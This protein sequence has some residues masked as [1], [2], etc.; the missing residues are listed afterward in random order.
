M[1][2]IYFIIHSKF[3]SSKVA[4]ILFFWHYYVI[5]IYVIHFYVIYIYVIL[6]VLCV[7]IYMFFPLLVLFQSTWFRYTAVFYILWFIIHTYICNNTRC[8]LYMIMKINI[9][10]SLN[11]FHNCPSKTIFRA[12][13]VEK[14]R[15]PIFPP[16]HLLN[17]QP[18][19]HIH[20]AT[21]AFLSPLLCAHTRI[22]QSVP[23][24]YAASLSARWC[25]FQL[26]PQL[27]VFSALFQNLK[28]D[29][30]NRF[31]PPDF[32]RENLRTTV[33]NNPRDKNP[34][35][36]SLP[37]LVEYFLLYNILH[38]FIFFIISPF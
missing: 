8:L 5:L 11:T 16:V 38:I 37:L 21:R 3:Q 26:F 31:N 7:S 19:V 27:C 18:S 33:Q 9:L 35:S 24:P 10:E 36:C 25:L 28:S 34:R 17:V 30:F 22:Q 6:F 32:R 2:C 1:E 13:S 4:F 15:K 20:W 14:S 29:I 23:T 12:Y